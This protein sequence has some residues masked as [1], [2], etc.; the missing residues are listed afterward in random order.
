MRTSALIAALALWLAGVAICEDK[1]A[2][3]VTV[4]PGRQ[5]PVG[6]VVYHKSFP[7]DFAVDDA[8]FKF[9]VYTEPGSAVAKY[10]AFVNRVAAGQGT[11]G[12]DVQCANVGKVIRKGD[13]EI[14]IAVSWTQGGHP[15]PVLGKLVVTGKDEDGAPVSL[16]V[17]SDSTWSCYYGKLD[18]KSATRVGA[19]ESVV[20]VGSAEDW[21]KLKSPIVHPKLDASKVVGVGRAR[22][23]SG[24][25]G[26]ADEFGAIKDSL[27]KLDM[28]RLIG[29]SQ[30]ELQVSARLNFQYPGQWFWGYEK[31]IARNI[32]RAG[33]KMSLRPS[34]MVPPDWL[35]RRGAIQLAASQRGNLGCPFISPWDPVVSALTSGIYAESA[36][37]LGDRVCAV[38]P[39]VWNPWSD[40]IWA[41]DDYARSA[42]VTEFGIEP[43]SLESSEPRAILRFSNWYHDRITFLTVRACSEARK[44]FPKLD[45]SPRVAPGQGVDISAITREAS[46]L[47]CG[48]RAVTS[49]IVDIL[50]VS[51]AARHYGAPLSLEIPGVLDRPSAARTLFLAASEGVDTICWNAADIL[52]SSDI[53]SNVRRVHSAK[54]A[55][56]EIAVFYPTSWLRS[57]LSTS[58]A[59]LREAA[60]ELRDYTDFDVVDERLIQDGALSLYRVLVL[61]DGNLMDRSAYDVVSAWV[62]KGGVL[63]LSGH[64]LPLTDVDGAPLSVSEL[65]EQAR[66]G[67]A[68]AERGEGQIIVWGGS[69]PEERSDYY[70]LIY[71]A[72]YP[73]GSYE[74]ADGLADGVWTA[75]YKNARVYCNTGK[76]K[77]VIV[78][79]LSPDR[80]ERLAPGDDPRRLDYSF[81]I[82][83][84]TAVTRFLDRPNFETALECEA[85]RGSEK[86]ETGVV[87]HGGTWTPGRT[88]RATRGSVLKCSLTIPWDG[89]YRLALVGDGS[90][91]IVVDGK[92]I[93]VVGKESQ[94][95][96][97]FYPIAGSVRLRAGEHSISLRFD[98]AD[99]SVDKLMI[100]TDTTLTGFAYGFTDPGFDNSW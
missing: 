58:P 40:D 90:A 46:K 20:V 39:D 13:N 71:N 83:P 32:E 61:V 28:L 89:D 41:F 10:Q 55:E 66:D 63:V 7:V 76:A 33:L 95:V 78:S 45:I 75:M 9:T 81:D 72:A 60:T 52:S 36:V 98:G 19:S 23:V 92:V 35:A 31:Q 53:Y 85:M 2:Q 77:A 37:G 14:D 47:K 44:S 100:S 29:Y 91:K 15:G 57:S 87:S 42:H 74:G 4:Q 70:E 73:E 80:V 64:Q 50:R 16:T 96:R 6:S 68:V 79:E 67:G 8:R 3:W 62:E 18:P 94:G 82:D 27:D 54:R 34:V 26:G 43:P 11:Y 30:V 86:L 17:R 84:L 93:G 38:A 56:K 69:W 22:L 24:G 12:P 97:R 99:S 59:R 49:H 48:V 21:P 65:T 88:V 51:T 5:K 25:A 1:T